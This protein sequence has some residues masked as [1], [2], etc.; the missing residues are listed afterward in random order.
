MAA[1]VSFAMSLLPPVKERAGASIASGQVDPVGQIARA[2]RPA[3]AQVQ[4]LPASKPPEL[5]N[6]KPADT[7]SGGGVVG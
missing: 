7:T 3:R 2:K 4:K 6:A 1:R 5:I